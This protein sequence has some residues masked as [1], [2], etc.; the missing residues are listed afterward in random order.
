MNLIVLKEVSRKQ[1]KKPQHTEVA[2]N[3]QL[4][5]GTHGQRVLEMIKFYVILKEDWMKP[6]KRNPL[7]CNK[8]M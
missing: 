2:D 5:D 7:K 4:N 6:W 1:L 3:K 8:Y